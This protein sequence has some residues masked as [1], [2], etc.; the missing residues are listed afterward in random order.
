MIQLSDSDAAILLG[1]TLMHWG[2]PFRRSA[3]RELSEP[4]QALAD[5][6][7]EKLI[8]LRQACRRSEVKTVPEVQLSVQ[9]AALLISVIED[10]L[11]ECGDDPTEIRLQLKANNRQ[12]VEELLERLRHSLTSP[13]ANYTE[14]SAVVGGES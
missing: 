13:H 5:D 4:Q 2:V 12:E 11:Q 8:A 1:A 7:S 14:P 9:E 3:R 10:C 6:A